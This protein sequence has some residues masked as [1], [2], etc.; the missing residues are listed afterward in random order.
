MQTH[1]FPGTFGFAHESKLTTFEAIESAF[2]GKEAETVLVARDDPCCPV[3]DFD[4]VSFGHAFS[5][6]GM[7]ALLSDSWSNSVSRYYDGISDRLR[8]PQKRNDGSRACARRPP[9]V[10]HS[11]SCGNPQQRT[12]LRQISGN[13]TRWSMKWVSNFTWETHPLVLSETEKTNRM[14]STEVLRADSIARRRRNVLRRHR[15]AT[16]HA[17]RTAPLN[18][19]RMKSRTSGV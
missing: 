5:F 7:T 11:I 9:L 6:A 13:S 18:F 12:P 10:C 15:H 8:L 17:G 16:Y 3:T 19:V 1:A 14:I 2:G 4:N